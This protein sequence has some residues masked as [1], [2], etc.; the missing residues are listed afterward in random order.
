MSHSSRALPDDAAL[1]NGII[2]EVSDY[3][4]RHTGSASISCHSVAVYD[5]AVRRGDIDL[6]P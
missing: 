1:F 5:A 2:A 3:V 4:S 6:V